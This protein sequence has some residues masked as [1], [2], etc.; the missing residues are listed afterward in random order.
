MVSPKFLAFPIIRNLSVVMCKRS[1]VFLCLVILALLPFCSRAEGQETVQ[2]EDWQYSRG[3]HVPDPEGI[4]GLARDTQNTPPEATPDWK[5]I[6]LP[7]LLSSQEAGRDYTGWITLRQ[8]LPEGLNRALNERD[9]ELAL[10]RS[11][12]HGAHLGQVE[13]GHLL[14]QWIDPA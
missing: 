12:H 1:A 9:D 5:P 7:A 13:V 2:L 4:Q 14:A 3:L 8:E 11:L 6:E 10:D